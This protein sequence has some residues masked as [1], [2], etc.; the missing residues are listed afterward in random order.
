[1]YNPESIT[2]RVHVFVRDDFI[3]YDIN[4]AFDF[5]LLSKRSA[6][7]IRRTAATAYRS[8]VALQTV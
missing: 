7:T 1:M 6:P 3:P 8:I 2:A 4:V 5:G